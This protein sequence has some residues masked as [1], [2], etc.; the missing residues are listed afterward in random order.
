[1][2]DRFQLLHD[3]EVLHTTGN[4]S[5]LSRLEE[6]YKSKGQCIKLWDTKLQQ[7]AFIPNSITQPKILEI[8]DTQIKFRV[9]MNSVEISYQGSPWIYIQ[10][11]HYKV[12]KYVANRM[13]SWKVAERMLKFLR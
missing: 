3:G 10:D 12:L 4:L 1:M 9:T 5:T 11:D 8:P 6:H 7:E 13:G 2:Q